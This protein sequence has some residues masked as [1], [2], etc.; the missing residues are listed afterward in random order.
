MLAAA[1]LAGSAW[2]LHPPAALPAD[3]PAERFSA[4]RALGHLRALVPDAAPRPMGSD[5]HARSRAALGAALRALGLEAELQDTW[6]Q[7]GGP[8]WTTLARVQNVLARL[9]GREDLPAILLLAHYDSVPAGPGASDDAAGCAALLEVVRALRHDGPRRHPI[10][11]LFADG[12]EMGLLGA[13]AFATGHPAARSVGCVINLEARGTTGASVMFETGRGNAPWIAALAD[14]GARLTTNSVGVLAYRL[15]PNDT[16]LS[17]FLDLGVPGF[18]FA[19]IGGYARY[20]T[21]LDTV[22]SVDPASLQQQGSAALA[23]ARR[24]A[25]GL[26][27]QGA[28]G[29]AVFS[30]ILGLGLLRLPASAMVPLAGATLALLLAWFVLAWRQAGITI[31][32]IAGG[33][34]LWLAALG[35]S[36]LALFVLLRAQHYGGAMP[37]PFPASAFA[38]WLA[39]LGSTALLHTLA[40]ILLGPRCGAAVLA[41]VH[42]VAGAALALGLGLQED[43]VLASH[44]PLLPAMAAAL[45]L[46][47]AVRSRTPCVWWLAAAAPA[48]VAIPLWLPVAV[49][50]HEGLGFGVHTAVL[51]PWLLLPCLPL[52]AVRGG[53][54]RLAIPGALCLVTMAAGIA[55]LHTPHYTPQAPQR[56]AL[57]HVQD[58]AAAR[59]E[60]HM[61]LLVP[62]ASPGSLPYELRRAR[63]FTGPE[64]VQ[65][66]LWWTRRALTAPAQREDLPPPR[67]EILEARVEG[68]RR[69]VRVRLRSERGAGY[70]GLRGIQGFRVAAGPAPLEVGG[71]AWTLGSGLACTTLPPEGLTLELLLPG[72]EPAELVL[73][74]LSVG[75]PGQHH[76]LLAARGDRAGTFQ[77]GDAV[78]VATRVRL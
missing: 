57:V 35:T 22:E 15:M 60:A 76:D 33:V 9:P 59:I 49:L 45:S 54:A 46:L 47:L 41:G 28:H 63:R 27:A 31:G 25:D 4:Q 23:L 73:H 70:A 24:L 64:P 1:L 5:A 38:A 7:R 32:R 37:T 56:L 50:V 20:H 13:H 51:V 42:G 55:W 44:L 29:D 68:V 65:Y 61:P 62:H 19:W 2:R 40:G 48:L 11:V 3:A 30:D 34:L 39:L 16:D 14:A 77:W 21:P 43:Y 52:W 26:P 18:N 10:L 67:L 71:A 12:E 6:T 66:P 69:V 75:L 78:L 8:G 17:V 58:D 36:A 72:T 53:P 74:D